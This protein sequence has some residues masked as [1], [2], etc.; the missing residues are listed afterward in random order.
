MPGITGIIGRGSAEQ[1]ASQLT[2]MVQ[3][4]RRERFYTSATYHQESLGLAAGWVVHRSSFADGNPVWNAARDI[5]LILTGEDFSDPADIATLRA[6]GHGS[7][8]DNAGY[9]IQGYEALGADFLAR[10]NGN[11]SGIL[12]DLRLD[13]VLL[14]NDRYGL[15]RIYVHETPEGVYFSSEAKSILSVAPG[16]RELDATGMAEFLSCG[17]ALQNR[18]L[19]KAISLLPPA[20]CWTFAGGALV[21]RQSYFSVAEWEQLEPL[22]EAEFHDQLNATFNRIVPKYF[23]GRERVGMSL[24]GGLDGRM[25][26]ACSKRELGA[27]PC[28][29]F[30][31]TYR[32]CTDVAFA[33][34]IAR[35]CGQSHQVIPVGQ[36]FIRQFGAL[37]E[38][39]VYVSDGAMDVTGSVELFAN[40][41]AREIAPV[42]LTGNYGSEI[43]RSNIAFRP[44]ALSSSLFTPELMQRSEAA[45][46]IYRQEAGGRRL[47]TIA[48]KQV[49]W[50]HHS[51]LSVEQSQLTMRSPYLDNELMALAYR[52]P[53]GREFS[54]TPAL[55]FIAEN[56]ARLSGVP[57]DR[58]LLYQPAP[59]VGK[60]RNLY[61]EFTFKAEYAYDYGMPQWLA[62]IDHQLGFLQLERAF[63][64]RH[65]FY[66]FRVWYR[67]KLRGY[68]QEVLLD[69]RS[70][71]RPYLDGSRLK[72]LVKQHLAGT[73][74]HTNEL[75]QALSLELIQRKL[76][77]AAWQPH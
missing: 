67:D 48:T 55:R 15:G 16:T 39:S 66:H 34:E 40:R 72:N 32:D 73:H 41:L 74:N 52:T 2:R 64:G 56:D 70:L 54:K 49:P 28:Y 42:R 10:L 43:L 22:G 38:E 30:G 77:E 9:L 29:T 71:A 36:S 61:Q 12:V 7:L 14:F 21:D 23:S 76:I 3:V 68:L 44:Q 53:P 19:F 27:I 37:A 31:G 63:L 8:S 62:R 59:V 6:K 25:I 57:T 69:P 1:R 50:H 24:T 46:A 51:R 18:T 60:L 11:V 20:S 26:M 58:G 5:C 33:R 47:S 65:K 45:A 75:H 4:M 35:R 17:C 13:K